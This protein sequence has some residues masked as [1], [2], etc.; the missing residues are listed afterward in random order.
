[1]RKIV[2]ILTIM[3]MFAGFVSAQQKKQVR[4]SAV[5]TE[6]HMTFLGVP[7]TGNR[8]A[9]VN[10][11]KANNIVV[12]SDF[13]NKRKFRYN[14]NQAVVFV[15]YELDNI[16]VPVDCSISYFFKDDDVNNIKKCVNR[17]IANVKTNFIYKEQ[18]RHIWFDDSDWGNYSIY[19]I[20][21]R[22]NQKKK[23]GDI[24]ITENYY[25]GEYYLTQTY[26]DYSN[27]V[28][29]NKEKYEYFNYD[30]KWYDYNY[31]LY[32]TTSLK[33]GIEQNM[34]DI[35]LIV[36]PKGKQPRNYILDSEGKNIFYNLIKYCKDAK[37]RNCFIN[38]FLDKAEKLSEVFPEEYHLF[39]SLLHSIVAD[40][41]YDLDKK[42]KEESDRQLAQRKKSY[43]FMDLMHMLAPGFF[44]QDDVE[45]WNKLP[46]SD[47]K[48]VINGSFGL[49]G[50][51]GD[52][53]GHTEK[54]HTP[55]LRNQQ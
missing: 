48:A 31:P 1:M 34:G 5:S 46:K 27:N 51:M 12:S 35:Y 42:Q 17:V 43:G 41:Y 54:M 45:L 14:G 10:K 21:S 52:T 11:L 29:Y 36:T 22:K 49:F 16:N 28:K 20:Y 37:L 6:E 39:G 40:Y 50:A 53:R 30:I 24:V 33:Y 38:S 44:T 2:A 13:E 26:Y 4:K 32:N 25:N 47:Q 18:V 23:I 7:M 15:N 8:T 3:F 9:F 55:S 19:T